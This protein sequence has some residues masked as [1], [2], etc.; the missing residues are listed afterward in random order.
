MSARDSYVSI[1]NL[2]QGSTQRHLYRAQA[3][4]LSL[5]MHCLLLAGWT[6]DDTGAVMYTFEHVDY[7]ELVNNH[8]TNTYEID[9]RVSDNNTVR[10]TPDCALSI[11]VRLT[12]VNDNPPVWTKSSY[13]IPSCISEVRLW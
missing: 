11:C 9:L 3:R 2:S 5:L 13:D 1:G 7:E 8:G 10:G 4:W 12:D 6:V